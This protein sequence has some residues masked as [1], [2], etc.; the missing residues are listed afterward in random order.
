[1]MTAVNITCEVNYR[2]L[3]S[4]ESVSFDIRFSI[5]PYGVVSKKDILVRRTDPSIRLCSAFEI[6][7]QNDVSD[8]FDK[9]LNAITTNDKP[10]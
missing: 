4:T 6:D 7:T 9:K 8:R 3:L 10:K 2:T 1:M 5:R